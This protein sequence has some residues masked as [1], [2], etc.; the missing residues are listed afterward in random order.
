MSISF[1]KLG[2]MSLYNVGG[3]QRFG[4]KGL[5]IGV[6]LTLKPHS[7]PRYQICGLYGK[8]ELRNKCRGS[9]DLGN[10]YLRDEP[11]HLSPDENEVT[12]TVRTLEIVL[13]NEQL[14]K[15]EEV[16]A[17]GDIEFKAKLSG[18]IFH[19]GFF[20]E[21]RM[22]DLYIEIPQSEWVKVL[23][24][25]GF[26][27]IFLMEVPIPDDYKHPE[28]H[29]SHKHILRAK[30]H[31]DVGHYREAVGVCRDAIEAM[32]SYISATEIGDP[33]LQ[34]MFRSCN[35]WDRNERLQ[36]I[37]RAIKVF[38]H[39]ARHAKPGTLKTDFSRKDAL[40]TISM[41]NILI[42]WY[43]DDISR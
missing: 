3:F 6:E 8:L 29:E 14:E 13:S 40:S 33:N 38:T 15:L 2:D 10:L 36:A 42:Q 37:R 28:L 18:R 24:E 17:G 39:P 32:D 1:S 7:S 30:Q 19:Q 22:S 31:L 27:R 35:S 12:D 34:E 21:L 20:D 41:L 9:K 5:R 25:I 11:L 4:H 16:R 26:A 23:S 43:L